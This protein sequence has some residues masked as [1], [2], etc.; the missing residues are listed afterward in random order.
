MSSGEAAFDFTGRVALVT[1]AGRGIGRAIAGGFLA[2]GAKVVGV[3]KTAASADRLARAGPDDGRLISLAGDVASAQVAEDAVG[4]AVDRFGRLDML[5]NNAGQRSKRG[6]ISELDVSDW[7]EVQAANVRSMFLFCR[8]A[9]GPLR[10]ANPGHVVNIGSLAGFFGIGY[11]AAYSASK[12]AVAQ[13]TKSLADD[14]ASK[15]IQVNAIA[16]GYVETDMNADL[17]H[18]DPD[19]ARAFT[20]RIPLERWGR[21]DEL[22]GPVLFLCTP[23]ASYIHG[24]VLPVDGGVLAR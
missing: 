20:E 3:S 5:I 6:P 15:G 12:G 2:A 9:E 19:R 10:D 1:G 21:P 7:D 17:R 14:W 23:T 18:D 11:A 16:P 8:A 22:V 13:L 24:A 4:A